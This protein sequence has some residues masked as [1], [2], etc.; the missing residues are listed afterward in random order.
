MLLHFIL[1]PYFSSYTLLAHADD[2]HVNIMIHDLLKYRKW[3]DP[4][5]VID[6]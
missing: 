2:F 6:V 5:E 4:S 3:N 1:F